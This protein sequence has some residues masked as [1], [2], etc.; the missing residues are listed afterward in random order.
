MRDV[1][2]LPDDLPVPI[3][4][5]A[6]DH[7]KGMRFPNQ[8]LPSTSGGVVNFTTLN[9]IVVCYFYPMIGDP[10]S[11]PGEDWNLIPGA[12]GCTPQSCAFRDNFKVFKESDVQIFGVSSQETTDQ[13]EAKKRLQLPFDLISDSSFSLCHA[14]KLPTFDYQAKPYIKRLTIIA[15]DGVIEKVLYPVFPSYSDS[16]E[17]LAWLSKKA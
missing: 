12:R 15:V 10:E 13:L 1:Y 4:D 9:G 6:C 5:G 7:L 14:L 3:D 11:L 2:K 8:S 16:S 17:I